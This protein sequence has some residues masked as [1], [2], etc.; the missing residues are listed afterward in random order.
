ME[1][2]RR[3]VLPVALGTADNFQTFLDNFFTINLMLPYEA[4]LT[5]RGARPW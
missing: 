3:V 4:I 1:I 2:Y 5:W